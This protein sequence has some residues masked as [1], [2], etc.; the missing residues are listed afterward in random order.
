VR[1]AVA[2]GVGLGR[3]E[4]DG[5]NRAVP[6]AD[7]QAARPREAAPAEMPVATRNCR[8]VTELRAGID[9]RVHLLMFAE[10]PSG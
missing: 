5:V 1:G 9:Y 3:G 10:S 8:R 2:V 6:A 4:G 7:W